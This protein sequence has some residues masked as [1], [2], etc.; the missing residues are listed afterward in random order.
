M[1]KKMNGKLS[2]KNK[3]YEEM[4]DNLFI[5]L[6]PGLFRYCCFL[7]K[8]KWD[9]EDIAQEAILKAIKHYRS[10]HKL[11][12]A[13]LNKIAYHHWID[14]LRKRK[15]E[16]NEE[17]SEVNSVKEPTI[18]E[19]VEKLIQRFTPKQAVIFMLKEA[20]QYKANEIAELL[21]ISETAVKSSL[22]R[23][24]KRLT[25]NHAYDVAPFWSDEEYNILPVLFYESLLAQDP[26]V[27][28]KALPAI[29]SISN[30]SFVPKLMSRQS[31][32][33]QS[34]PATILSMAA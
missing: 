8:N 4:N 26:S 20:F 17:E 34:T 5:E 32:S 21:E 27:L 31:K 1:S 11:S 16:A 23:A 3:Q 33:L 28:I 24:K 14:T 9:G 30:E 6:Y 25:E 18:I 13:L 12:A 7:S 22:H 2:E 15:Q 10:H 19:T 29:H